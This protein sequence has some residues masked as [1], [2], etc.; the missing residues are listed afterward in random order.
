MCSL[1]KPFI[2]WTIDT[3]TLTHLSYIRQVSW[4]TGSA[5]SN[6]VGSLDVAA[7]YEEKEERRLNV[8]KSTVS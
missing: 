8:F 2:H 1:S 3:I 5:E 4:E 7:N 6:V